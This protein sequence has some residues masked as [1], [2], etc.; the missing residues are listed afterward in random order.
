M[1]IAAVHE[2]NK[3][4]LAREWNV[5][6]INNRPTAIDMV[7]IVSKGYDEQ[8][9]TSIMRH[10]IGKVAA[11]S[12]AKVEL[13]QEE[14]L[15]LNNEFYVTFYAGGKLYEKKF[16]FEKHTVSDKNATTLPVMEN[17]GVLAI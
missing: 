8:V 5:Y 10:G 12:Y 16:L 6:V 11:G 13:M 14:V 2:W 1:H 15:R 3:E 17:Q 9:K 7:L 4:F